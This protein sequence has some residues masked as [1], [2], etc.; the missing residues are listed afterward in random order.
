MNLTHVE[1]ATELCSHWKLPSNV[2]Q[3][4]LRHHDPTSIL[5]ELR[6]LVL[7]VA[8]ANILA[9]DALKD[10]PPQNLGLAQ[11]WLA[12]LAGISLQPEGLSPEQLNPQIG[13]EIER[14]HCFEDALELG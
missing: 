14:A 11:S 4:V 5:D 1:V 3:V 13:W 10:A 12:E 6:P 2:A 8:I 9:H 7:C